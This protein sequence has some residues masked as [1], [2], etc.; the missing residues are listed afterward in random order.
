M[1]YT[2]APELSPNTKVYRYMELAKFLSLI[3]QHYLFFARASSYEDLLEGMPTDLDSFMGSGVAQMLDHVVN[4]LWPAS[5]EDRGQPALDTKAAADC[6]RAQ[7]DERVVPTVLGQ[8]RAEDY[9]THSAIFEAVSDWVD[10]S[11][12]HTD[13]GGA[14]SMA[15]W[16]IYGA[17]AAAVCVQST[18]GAVM[19]AMRIPDQMIV[20]AGIVTY[21][22]YQNDYVG[23]EDPKQ[24]FF[25]KSRPYAFEKEVRLIM[26]PSAETDPR[27]PRLEPGSKVAVDA[28]HLIQSVL[29]SPVASAWFQELIEVV[30][31]EAGFAVPVKSSRIPYR[32]G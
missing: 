24:V 14:E 30:L 23:N 3:H 17:G 31:R 12:W 21:L 22:D 27:Q 4:G 26:Y 25:Q 20:H 16:K 28:K 8:V 15:M 9:P 32:R 6:A 1:A 10:V 13:D 29:I 2:V 11:C 7:F 19:E 18:L 5:I